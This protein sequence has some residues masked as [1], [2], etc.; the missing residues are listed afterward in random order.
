MS[1]EGERDRVC[2]RY[3]V[4]FEQQLAEGNPSVTTAFRNL[5]ALHRRGE[6]LA[7]ECWCAPKRCHADTLRNAILRES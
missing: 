6:P 3:A 2:D 1:N 4:W 5:V 7:L